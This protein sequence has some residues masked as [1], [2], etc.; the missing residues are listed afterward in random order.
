VYGHRHAS[1]ILS[2]KKRTQEEEE[3]EEKEKTTMTRTT[4]TMTSVDLLITCNDVECGA[5]GQT[6]NS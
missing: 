5:R 6:A 2:E 4:K 1:A 3:E